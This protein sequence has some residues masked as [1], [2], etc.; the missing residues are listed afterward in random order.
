MARIVFARLKEQA[1]LITSSEDG[2]K[3]LGKY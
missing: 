1:V 2:Y 3:S